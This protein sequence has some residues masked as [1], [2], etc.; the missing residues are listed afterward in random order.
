MADEK[1]LDEKGLH[2]IGAVAAFAAGGPP[3]ITVG[4]VI[5]AA[6]FVV[7]LVD[8][9]SNDTTVPDALRRLRESIEKIAVVIVSIDQRLNEL[10]HELAIE[11]NRQT[12]AR[13]NIELDN[14]RLQTNR[15]ADQPGN[16]DVAVDVANE[17]GV[18]LDRFL[19]ADFELWRWV[20][21]VEKNGQPD[22]EIGRFKNVPTLPVYLLG[23][24]SWLAARQRVVKADQRHRLDDDGP[25]VSRHLI[26]VSV[27]PEFD[28]YRDGDAGRPTTI[29]ENIKWRVRGTPIASNK[30]AEN[31]T[32]HFFYEFRNWMNGDLA[33]GDQFDIVT[34][35]DGV[36]CTVDPFSLGI[37]NTE[38]DWEI[39]AGV[40]VLHEL[41]EVLRRVEATGSVSQQFIGHFGTSQAFFP[42]ILY[43]IAQN[44][45]LHWYRNDQAGR[46]GGSTTWS[47][48]NV[49]GTGFNGFTTFFNGGGPA[50]YGI[51]RDGTLIWLG[52]EGRHSGLRDAWLNNAQPKQ[53]GTGWD[54]FTLVFSTGEF[55]IYGI[56]PDGRLLW[57]RH[58]GARVG[59]GDAGDWSGPNEVGTGWGHF[60]KV[61]SPGEG[62]IYA[63]DGDGTLF[64]AV[65]KGYLDGTME[66]EQGVAQQIAI[67][68]NTFF[69]VAPGPDGV[70][71]GFR[72]DG[73]VFYT[74]FG[75]PRTESSSAPLPGSLGSLLNPGATTVVGAPPALV[76]EGPPIEIT[77]NLPGFISV[78]AQL[79]ETTAGPIVH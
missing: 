11:S 68:W 55:V 54:G 67:G 26:A 27:R 78:C 32:C 40:E 4:A 65:H 1:K 38:I 20:D 2:L 48:P 43:V 73:R 39:Q 13:L 33:R 52:Y 45:D 60:V 8:F 6:A 50:M 79:D 49:I 7:E 29:A 42:G 72:R 58:H 57:F 47:G 71:Y 63:I 37:P 51:Q 62:V 30:F 3:G 17:L 76:W 23:V 15:M 61:F 25:R 66:W 44:G 21:V 74:R 28:K 16:I 77:H 64:R 14:I 70:I 5:A 36:L 41:A 35:E 19:R 53:V 75:A 24:M 22:A 46:P 31:R 56:T 69:D 34:G 12:L 18:V 59:G 10:T 9:M